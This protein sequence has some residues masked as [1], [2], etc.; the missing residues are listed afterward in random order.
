MSFPILKSCLSVLFLASL[1]ACAFDHSDA[2]V[3]YIKI[4]TKY[5]ADESTL[6]TISTSITAITTAIN[7]ASKSITT[8]TNGLQTVAESL[9]SKPIQVATTINADNVNESIR[10]INTT[11]RSNIA[12]MGTM[13]NSVDKTVTVKI[14]DISSLSALISKAAF[15]AVGIGCTFTGLKLVYDGIHGLLTQ[16]PEPQQAHTSPWERIKASFR[17]HASSLT[18]TALGAAATASGL[19]LIKHADACI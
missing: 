16:A 4:P 1:S 12:S 8:A 9:T 7:N 17:H 19:F 13:L 11:L 18:M 6:T 3:G 14:A 2:G 15:C 10:T 5:G